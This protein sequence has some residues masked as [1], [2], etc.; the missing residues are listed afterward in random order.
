MKIQTGLDKESPPGDLSGRRI[1]V[2]YTEK[3]S[4]VLF[5]FTNFCGL[6]KYQNT[7]GQKYSLGD[8]YSSIIKIFFRIIEKE[9]GNTT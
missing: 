2:R 7:V 6:G 1:N 4:A 5:T 8:I 9:T 3:Y